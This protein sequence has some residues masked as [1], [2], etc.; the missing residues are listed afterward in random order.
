V[1]GGVD[2][3]ELESMTGAQPS[4]AVYDIDADTWSMLPDAPWPAKHPELAWDGDRLLYAGGTS[5]STVNSQTVVHRQAAWSLATGWQ[6][7]PTPN[8]EVENDFGALT[9]RLTDPLD[10]AGIDQPGTAIPATNHG[11]SF[12][13]QE[14]G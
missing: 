10:G 2:A 9:V 5:G 11:M 3:E 6:D 8:D 13:A 1:V 4:G 14:A 12:G 7:L